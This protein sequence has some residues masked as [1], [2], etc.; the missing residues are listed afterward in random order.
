MELPGIAEASLDLKDT[1]R[2]PCQL[3]LDVNNPTCGALGSPSSVPTKH[4]AVAKPSLA[5]MACKPVHT[6]ACGLL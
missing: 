6:H 3:C 1:P 4:K 5:D 2:Q